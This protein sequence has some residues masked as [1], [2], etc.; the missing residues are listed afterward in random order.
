MNS[1]TAEQWDDRLFGGSEDDLLLGGVGG[2]DNLN[3]DSETALEKS[4]RQSNTP[5]KRMAIALWRCQLQDVRIHWSAGQCG[6]PL[7]K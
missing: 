4:I 1:Y 2:D 6:K 5:G 3:G 7:L